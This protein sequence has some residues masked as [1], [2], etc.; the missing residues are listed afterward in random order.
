MEQLTLFTKFEVQLA[1]N[2]VIGQGPFTDSMFIETLQGSKKIYILVLFDFKSSIFL[3]KRKN[4]L[5]S[6][7]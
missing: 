5:I 1:A 6:S 3:L 2:N 4:Y 7:P